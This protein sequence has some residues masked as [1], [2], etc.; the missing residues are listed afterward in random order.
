MTTV[1]LW[2]AEAIFPCRRSGPTRT[3]EARNRSIYLL[4]AAVG[5]AELM[6]RTQQS[7]L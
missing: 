5:T 1:A 6:N 2:E 4:P 7:D 3:D